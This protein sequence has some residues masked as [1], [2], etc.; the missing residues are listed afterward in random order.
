MSRS[1]YTVV[2]VSGIPNGARAASLELVTGLAI[3]PEAAKRE[4]TRESNIPNC[5]VLDQVLGT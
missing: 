2:L 5:V 3:A 4:A 1:E